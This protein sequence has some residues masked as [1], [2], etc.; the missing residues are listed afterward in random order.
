MNLNPDKVCN[1]DCIYCQVDRS[2]PGESKFVDVDRL[3]DEYLHELDQLIA[4]IRLVRE[5]SVRVRV[6]IMALGE[7]MSTRLGASYLNSVGVA[8]E[9]MDARDMLLSTSRANRGRS[10]S[11]LSAT[12]DHAADAALQQRMASVGKLVLT[13]GFIA[14]NAQGETVLLGR[15]GSDTSAAY[16]AAKL[17]ARRLEI[18]SDVPGMFTANP[19][20]VP[21]ARLLVALHYD[22]AQELASAGSTVLHPRCLS[23]LRSSGIPLFIRCTTHP[24]LEGTVISSVTEEGEPQVTRRVL[25]AVQ[26]SSHPSIRGHDE[27]GRGVRVLAGLAIVGVAE[28]EGRGELADLGLLP[29]EKVPADGRTRGHVACAGKGDKGN[30]NPGHRQGVGHLGKQPFV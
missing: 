2:T 6:R 17:Q 20:V 25:D 14:R 29:G 21:S 7:L 23:P 3:L 1:F 12:C 24:Q 5:V 13:Q 18:W 27:D 11:Y 22:E 15:G 28:T 16:M 4:G 30:E 19:R 8:T 9:W 10:R 26:I